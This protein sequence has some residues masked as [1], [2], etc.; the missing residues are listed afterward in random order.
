MIVHPAALAP[1]PQPAA[2][3]PRP[4]LPVQADSFQQRMA[5]SHPVRGADL[6]TYRTTLAGCGAA[7]GAF[8]SHFVAAGL[9]IWA[10]AALAG[11]L[12]F[13]PIGAVVG[14]AI[15][16][17]A[18]VKVQFKTWMGREVGARLGAIAGD[19]AGK[20]AFAAGIP[21]P[22]HLVETTRN[23]SYTGM[24]EVLD[25][26]SHNSHP[27]ISPA[28]A[29]AF[30]AALQPGDVVLTND[31]ASTP[32]ALATLI[33]TGRGC[34]FTHGI[35]H[36]GNGKTVEARMKGGVQ[37]GDLISVLT[38]KHHAVALRPHYLPGQADATVAA[39]E[40]MIGKPYDFKFKMGN[41]SFYCSEAVYE[42][43]KTGAPQLQFQSRP[44][45]NREVIV[46]SDLLRTKDAD[47]VAEAGVGR[48]M[49]DAYLAKLVP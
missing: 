17:A 20:G 9:G 28:E 15:G 16:A 38:Q 26:V 44:V 41:D 1:V 23:F 29:Q 42:T 31:E 3:P 35:V 43:L 6:Q 40:A 30:V 19:F 45:L 46:P 25:D 33:L 5:E 36:T 49:F 13:G 24:R 39:A 22:S 37:R 21:L 4:P 8:G 47:V 11:A 32:F 2:A 48:T 14:G 10:G 18:A 34:D 7:V 12:G 27:R